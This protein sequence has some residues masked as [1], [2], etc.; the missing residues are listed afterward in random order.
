MTVPLQLPTGIIAEPAS[1]TSDEELLTTRVSSFRFDLLEPRFTTNGDPLPEAV[2]GT[3]DG[4]TGGEVSWTYNAAIKGGGSIDV[5]DVGQEIDWMRARIRPVAILNDAREVPI[6]VF[7]P[8]APKEAYATGQRSWPVELLDK[9]S[10]LDQD[11]YAD[12]ATGR[13]LPYSLDAGVDVMDAIRYLIE[14]VGESALGIPTDLGLTTANPLTWDIGTPRLQIINDLLSA[15]NYFSL[16]VDSM[17]QFRA[18]PYTDP[19]SRP[20]QYAL[21]APFEA[22]RFM[23]PD[24]TR[25][26][27]IYSIPNRFI[28]TTQGDEE[29]EGLMST[30]T[31][32]AS[33]PYS[34]AK[35]GR[36]V[37]GVEQ[38]VEVATQ[39]CLNRYAAWRL[40]VAASV[41]QRIE[42]SH[43][44][45]P[46]LRVN[47]NIYFQAADVPR[48]LCT[49]YKTSVVF[50]PLGLCRTELAEAVN[51][52]EDPLGDHAPE[53]DPDPE[54]GD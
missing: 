34:F 24:W 48:T 41:S 50:D 37:T 15:V 28:V 18:T 13:A 51:T 53:P 44:I 54:P 1:L 47:E 17:G 30:A 39:G 5:T 40:E 10:L 20:A 4:V 45:L 32:P 52:I 14:G 29:N 49:V 27:D 22:G 36:W 46:D 21:L 19:V 33:S 7:I 11:V 38:D 12:P 42:I 43:P 2:I 26:R 3:L 16:W 23:V 35:R 6:G 9:N 25:D 31:L 8:A